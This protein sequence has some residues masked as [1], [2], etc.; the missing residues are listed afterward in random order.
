MRK[1]MQWWRRRRPEWHARWIVRP[2]RGIDGERLVGYVMRR[3][4]GTGWVYRAPSEAERLE[5]AQDD[6]W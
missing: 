2:V 6:A 1:F 3:W 5:I 4:G